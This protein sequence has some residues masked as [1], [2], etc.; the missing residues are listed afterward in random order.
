[1]DVNVAFLHVELKEDVCIEPPA[2]YRSVA[3]GMMLKLNNGLLGL[4]QSPR[5]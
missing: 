4:K 2:G 5:E 1:M 3:N